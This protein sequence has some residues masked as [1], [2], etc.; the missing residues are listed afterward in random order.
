MMKLHPK[1]SKPH[2]TKDAVLPCINGFFATTSAIGSCNTLI[3]QNRDNGI[4]PAETS[5]PMHDTNIG[6]RAKTPSAQELARFYRLTAQAMPK[7]KTPQPDSTIVCVIDTTPW[8][9]P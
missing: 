3:Q 7:I 1:L 9:M 8:M 2:P 4:V 6:K 5:H